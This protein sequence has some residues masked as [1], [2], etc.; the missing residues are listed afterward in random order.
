MAHGDNQHDEVVIHI[1]KKEYKIKNPITG[2]ALY[3]LAGIGADY[4]LLMEIPGPGDDEPIPNDSKE[5]TFKNG[6]QFHSGPKTL[7]PGSINA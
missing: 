6:T 4:N 3:T 2:V 1:D 7:N 5:Y